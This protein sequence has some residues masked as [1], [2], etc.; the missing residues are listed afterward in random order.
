MICISTPAG[1]MEIRSLNGKISSAD[2]TGEYSDSSNIN[3]VEVACARQLHEY[4]SRQREAFDVPLLLNGSPFELAVWNQLLKIPYGETRSYGAVARQMGNPGAA[5]AVGMAC[6]RNKLAI[7]V[8]C[9]RILGKAGD[10]V[11]YASGTDKKNFL[12]SLEKRKEMLF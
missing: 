5:R 10:L 11:G 3:A 6:H 12:L 8:P 9:H 7:L 4:F 2:F 1:F